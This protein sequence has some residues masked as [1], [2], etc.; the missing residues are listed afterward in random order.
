[1]GCCCLALD[2]ELCELQ[3]LSAELSLQ[4]LQLVLQISVPLFSLCAEQGTVTLSLRNGLQ[5][6]VWILCTDDAQNEITRFLR[7]PSH[8]L[9]IRSAQCW[10][11]SGQADD[12]QTL[13]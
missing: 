7:S 3:I 2:S 5:K 1:M 10:S 6:P 11:M 4:A 9:C 8:R 13:C 12:M